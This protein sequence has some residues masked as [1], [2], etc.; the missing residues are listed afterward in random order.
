[1]ASKHV[2]LIARLHQRTLDGD[3]AWEETAEEGVYQLAF[4][5]YA[6]RFSRRWDRD[7][8]CFDYVL[9]IHNDEGTLIEEVTDATIL[10][11]LPNAYRIMEETYE[12]ARRTAMGVE[13]AL[14]ALIARLDSDL[15]F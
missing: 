9:S 13:K 8:S 1:M 10:Q 2:G 4:P 11:Q 5:D 3:L 14:D 15:P 7:E 12:T 6:M